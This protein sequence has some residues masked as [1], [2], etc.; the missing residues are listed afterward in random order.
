MH[1]SQQPS[2]N[3]FEENALRGI[4]ERKKER[5]KEAKR[6]SF[7]LLVSGFLV[8]VVYVRMSCCAMN[9]P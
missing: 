7:K 6:E 9:I 1:R 3:C 2:A 8:R 5:K 4:R